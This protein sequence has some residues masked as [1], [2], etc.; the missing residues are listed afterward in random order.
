MRE[1]MHTSVNLLD[2]TSRTPRHHAHVLSTHHRFS[3]PLKLHSATPFTLATYM[4]PPDGSK[5]VP[6][7][8]NS[9]SHSPAPRST[10]ASSDMLKCGAAP[11]ALPARK[12]SCVKVR[13]LVR[14][15]E[16]RF[17]I[18]SGVEGAGAGGAGACAVG[19]GD[20]ARDGACED[21]QSDSS[22][23]TSI[24]SPPRTCSPAYTLM[25]PAGSSVLVYMSRCRERIPWRSS[26]RC[27]SFSTARSPIGGMTT[28]S[29]SSSACVSKARARIRRAR[30]R[31]AIDEA[32][33]DESEEIRKVSWRARTMGGGDSRS[34]ETGREKTVPVMTTRG[35][36]RELCEDMDC[37]HGSSGT[38][39]IRTISSASKVC[40]SMM[41][42]SEVC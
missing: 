22:S 27:T 24:S 42:T 15:L 39:G 30:Q 16:V 11:L 21:A 1:V 31:A 14:P 4:Y 18:S 26:K 19:A 3:A 36:E 40:A 33:E 41:C 34:R 10:S 29:S 12:S 20:A 37:W 28:R 35:G 25:A 6:A 23:S 5:Q 2:N 8:S 38:L 32:C 13:R 17:D 9:K 7:K